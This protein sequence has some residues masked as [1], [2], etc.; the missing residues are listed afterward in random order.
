MQLLWRGK[1]FKGR[2]VNIFVAAV[3]GWVGV[4][5]LLRHYIHY[6]WLNSLI[7]LPINFC[8]NSEKKNTFQAQIL[9]KLEEFENKENL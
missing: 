7:T 9:T 2:E 4:N 5:S 6:C 8:R 3:E 1:S